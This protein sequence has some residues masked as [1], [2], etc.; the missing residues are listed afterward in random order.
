MQHTRHHAGATPPA[1]SIAT[2]AS[3]PGAGAPGA[4]CRQ[5]GASLVEG[6]IALAI[7]G[8]SLGA[9][10]PGLGDLQDKRRIEGA[11]AQIKTELAFA[12]SLAVEQRQA[13]RVG[14]RQ[15]GQHSCYVIHTGGPGA[16]TCD[17]GGT[18]TCT[19]PA[20]ALRT[21]AFDDQGR[22]S[23]GFNSSSIGFDPVKGTVTPTATLTLTTPTAHRLKLVIN[24][25]GRVR[26]CTDSGLRGY[27][28][29]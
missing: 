26:T 5:R 27:K 3:G 19:G 12:R 13:V 17:A 6:L 21:Q 10:A 16:C 25:L 18:A 2:P 24:I 28:P 7:I 14:L 11:A 9:L 8:I 4:R 15:I 1:P 22:L 29:C 20:R 23:L